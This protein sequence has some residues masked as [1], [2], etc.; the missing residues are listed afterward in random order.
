MFMSG[1]AV[2]FLLLFEKIS[3]KMLQIITFIKLKFLSQFKK[4]KQI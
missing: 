3:L 2:Y 1:I 4:K